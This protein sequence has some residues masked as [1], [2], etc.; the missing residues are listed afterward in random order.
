MT[1]QHI[2]VAVSI[3][4]RE[5]SFTS[6]AKVTAVGRVSLWVNEIN[7]S[8]TT[9]SH[10]FSVLI[11][12]NQ[13]SCPNKIYNRILQHPTRIRPP[14]LSNTTQHPSKKFKTRIRGEQEKE[15]ALRGTWLAHEQ[16]A[17]RENAKLVHIFTLIPSE[18]IK[19][20]SFSPFHLR[21]LK[22]LN[23]QIGFFRGIGSGIIRTFNSKQHTIRSVAS[24]LVLTSEA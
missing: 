12:N 14:T 8:E 23:T 4:C 2:D 3:I 15:N 7:V 24:R 22:P 5:S 9:P 6:G 11:D 16:T 10:L 21:N 20:T 19:N 1:V 17:P 18:L 13:K